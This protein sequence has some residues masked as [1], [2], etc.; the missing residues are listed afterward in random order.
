MG[1][2]YFDESIHDKAGFILGA[3]IYSDSDPTSLIENAIKK[4]ELTPGVDEFKSGIHMGKNPKQAELRKELRYIVFSKCKFGIVIIPSDKRQDLGK[5]A[6]FLLSMII[7]NND[8]SDK[9]HS[10]YFDENIF[11]NTKQRMALCSKLKLDRNCEFHFEQDS[12]I[13]YGIQL[14]DLVS[15]TCS[16]MLLESLGLIS[17]T[18]KAGENSGYGPDLDINLGFELWAGIRYNFFSVLPP[19]SNEGESQSD[20]EAIVESHGLHIAEG[21]NEDLKKAAKNRFGK[22]YLGCIH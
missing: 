6:L 13:I 9:R 12:R 10:V 14:A 21:C 18:I 3:Y 8:L 19:Y 20:Y 7:N 16:I 4:C 15:H 22:M 1:N 11:P 2:F 17:K 5:E